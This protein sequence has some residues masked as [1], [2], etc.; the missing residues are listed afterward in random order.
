M[1]KNTRTPWRWEMVATD[2]IQ[3]T[4]KFGAIGTVSVSPAVIG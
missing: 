2:S 4:G 1:E 3:S